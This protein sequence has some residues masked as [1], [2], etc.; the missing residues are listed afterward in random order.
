[1]KKIIIYSV[2]FFVVG[3][4][5]SP[6]LGMAIGETRN[7]ILG[8]AP[9][10]AVLSLADEIDKSR[11]ENEAKIQEL[12]GLVEQQKSELE[13]QKGELQKQKGEFIE[14]KA[15]T[16]QNI[17]DSSEKT[18]ACNKIFYY[19]NQYKATDKNGRNFSYVKGESNIDK[20]YKIRNE[21]LDKY[22]DD[23]MYEKIIN[24]II[25]DIEAD[26]Q[27]YLKVKSVCNK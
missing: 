13:I 24:S 5:L 27:D 26:Y 18:I 23:E 8:L 4:L 1:M 14:A 11:I 16:E 21:I 19:E 7:I 3:M 20:Y 25:K 12:Q 2:I 17:A 22:K 10:E 15:E 9:Q 6:I